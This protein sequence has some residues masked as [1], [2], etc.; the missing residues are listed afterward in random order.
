MG[1]GSSRDGSR[2]RGLRRWL[3]ARPVVF[4]RPYEQYPFDLFKQILN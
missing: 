4:V 2:A 1:E 3:A